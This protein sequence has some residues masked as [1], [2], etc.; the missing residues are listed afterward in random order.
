MLGEVLEFGQLEA[1]S[2]PQCS[3]HIKPET[4]PNYKPID[5]YPVSCTLEEYDEDTIDLIK[6]DFAEKCA[7]QSQCEFVITRDMM[8]SDQCDVFDLDPV[9]TQAIIIASCKSENIMIRGQQ[10]TVSK[11]AVALFVVLTDLVICLILWFSLL[12]LG[13]F[14]TT[15]RDEINKNIVNPIDYT[16]VVTQNPHKDHNDDLPGILWE[17][18]ENI[19]QKEME[20]YLDKELD[21]EEIDKYQNNVFNVSL[22]LNDV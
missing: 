20:E 10:V 15:T 18:A 21:T 6:Q 22:A 14:Q 3:K 19:N 13:P 1:A 7:D 17:W 11:G 4:S 12:M 16:V 8:P 2:F 9:E 5:Y